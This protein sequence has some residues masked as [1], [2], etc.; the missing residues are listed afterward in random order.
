MNFF[1]TIDKQKANR[2]RV[3]IWIFVCNTGPYHV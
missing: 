3:C 1:Q 2:M